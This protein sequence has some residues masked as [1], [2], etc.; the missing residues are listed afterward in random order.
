MKNRRKEERKITHQNLIGHCQGLSPLSWAPLFEYDFTGTLRGRK[1]RALMDWRKKS[2][3]RTSPNL[4]KRVQLWHVLHQSSAR[5]LSAKRVKRPPSTKTSLPRKAQNTLDREKVRL[6]CKNGR[7]KKKVDR[8]RRHNALMKFLELADNMRSHFVPG[9]PIIRRN[10]VQVGVRGLGIG[11]L[12]QKS[13]IKGLKGLVG[14]VSRSPAVGEQSLGKG[15]VWSI[16]GLGSVG[17]EE[18]CVEVLRPNKEKRTLRGGQ[19]ARYRKK[20]HIPWAPPSR[21]RI[22]AG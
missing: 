14:R 5:S 9:N 13:Q 16:S 7:E 20:V 19:A 15:G 2:D 10:R 12:G 11:G 18:K 1:D 22:Q 3:A 8:R 21:Q 17:V 6:K 4:Q